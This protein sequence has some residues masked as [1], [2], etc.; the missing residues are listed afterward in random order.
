MVDM[1]RE[2]QQLELDRL[3]PNPENP[4][5]M[6]DDQF[7]ALCE[8]IQE[9][10]FIQPIEVVARDDG[11]HNIVGGEHRWRA[12]RVLGETT[13]P[14]IV[15]GDEK[16]WDADRQAVN[17]VKRNVLH[18]ELNP[19][20]FSQ[21]FRRLEQS[22]G[23]EMTKQM[24]AFTKDDAFQ[25]VFLE[26][27]A[28]LPPDLQ[29]ALD[30][31]KDEIRTIDDLSSV[32]NRLFAEYGETLPS[33]FMVFSWGTK[34]VLWIQCDSAAWKAAEAM[35]AAAT[36]RHLPPAAVFAEV[37]DDHLVMADKPDNQGDAHDE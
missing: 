9:D 10:G 32:L 3:H 28:A 15:L 36:E 29:G 31:A 27:R 24:M 25:R 20:K 22:Y 4:N 17:L 14:C 18:G 37:W 30:A 2:I 19:V 34:K 7:N 1:V 26:A 12:L 23:R 6:S 8:S 5:E 11:D 35:V 16:T 13:G 21:L 33:D